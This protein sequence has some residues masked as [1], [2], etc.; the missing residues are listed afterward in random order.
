MKHEKQTR[1]IK[2]SYQCFEVSKLFRQNKGPKICI[3]IQ[4][5]PTFYSIESELSHFE[6]EVLFCFLISMSTLLEIN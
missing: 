6:L 3:I 1:R 2:L 5:S 4:N